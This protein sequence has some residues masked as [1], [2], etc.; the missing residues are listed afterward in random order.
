MTHRDSIAASSTAAG[1]GPVDP[2]GPH[3]GFA[4]TAVQGFTVV[5]PVL[6]NPPVFRVTT[7]SP[8]LTAAASFRD[9][10]GVDEPRKRSGHVA[11][12]PEND[13]GR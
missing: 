5:P 7:A 3:C 2:D 1:G 13:T 8:R 6:R 9:H 4:G 12:S 11:P 10:V